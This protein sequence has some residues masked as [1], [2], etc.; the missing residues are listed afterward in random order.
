MLTGMGLALGIDYSLF[1]VSRY[2]EERAQGRE[3]LDAI[4]ASAAHGEPRRR[5]QRHDVRARHVRDAA[6]AE[7]DLAQPG[8]RA[9]S[10]SGSSRSS[11]RDAAAR[12]CSGCSATAST[13][14]G[15][16]SSAGGSLESANPRAASGARRP[17]ASC[18]DRGSASRCQSRCS[19]RSPRLF[20][21]CTSERAAGLGASRPLRVEAGLRRPRR[22]LPGATDR[23]G[24]D[25]RRQGAR[26]P[27]AA[28]ALDRL[29]A[30]LAADPRFGEARS[31]RSPDGARR[32]ALGAVRGDPSGDERSRPC[33]SLA[34][35]SCRRRSPASD[36]DVLV[37]GTTAGE[38][39][40]LRLGHRPWRR[41]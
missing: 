37:G 12:R 20:S 27:V 29:R 16:R 10:S 41:G 33:A 31:R 7:H 17:R 1:V 38:H 32:R 3:Q 9:R 36:A 39:R 5:L 2:R 21:A 34:P 22:G 23:S 15:S 11:P 26:S 35:S 13:R 8:R 25:R 19:S 24:R 18:A 6:R 40:L 28:R 4:A 30:R 14:S